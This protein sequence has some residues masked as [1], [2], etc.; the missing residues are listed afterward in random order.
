MKSALSEILSGPIL[1]SEL[2]E[3][4]PVGVN[5]EQPWYLNQIM[6]G[7]YDGDAEMLLKKT[8]QIELD[9]GRIGKKMLAPRTADIDILL[10]GRQIVDTEDLKIPHPAILKRKFCLYGLNRIVPQW[11]VPGV[12]MSVNSLYLRM[13]SEVEAQK[14]RFL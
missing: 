1:A 10:F 2:M 12:E 7:L 5:E 14:I 11:I 8:L 13:E 6:C 9:L 3:T 4:E